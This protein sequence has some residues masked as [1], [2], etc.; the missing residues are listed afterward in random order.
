MIP[1]NY[2]CF[3]LGIQAA[4]IAHSQVER[5]NLHAA[6]VEVYDLYI[7]VLTDSWGVTSQSNNSFSTC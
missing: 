7:T 1:P 2:D 5:N 4:V 3:T 6:N